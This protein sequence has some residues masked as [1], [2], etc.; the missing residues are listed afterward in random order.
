MDDL[1]EKAE[2]NICPN[3]DGSD[4]VARFTF[5]SDSHQHYDDGTKPCPD[6]VP[7]NE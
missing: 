4:E 3:C 6:H 1:E 7:S 2:A 5:D